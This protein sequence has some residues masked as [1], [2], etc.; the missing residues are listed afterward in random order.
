MVEKTICHVIDA[1]IASLAVSSSLISQTIITSGSCL[2]KL[3]SHLAKVNLI[4]GLT[5]V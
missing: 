5:C 1:S 2:S 4:A 3:L